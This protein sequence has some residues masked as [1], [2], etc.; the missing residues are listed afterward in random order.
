M[1]FPYQETI[2]ANHL[3]MFFLTLFL[4]ITVES[5]LGDQRS[6]FTWSGAC[7]LHLME[8]LVRTVLT[9]L[10]T[11]TAVW[12]GRYLYVRACRKASFIGWWGFRGW[13]RVCCLWDSFYG[14]EWWGTC[15][16][17]LSTYSA[18][19]CQPLNAYHAR[20]GANSLSLSPSF[21]VIL[22]CYL[23]SKPH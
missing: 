1:F 20:R 10:T 17:I 2:F 8:L 6:N 14:E 7:I 12:Y 5:K 15:R 13:G 18:Y 9:G 23:W 16:P 4:K 21:P 11:G 3:W 19:Q 22:L